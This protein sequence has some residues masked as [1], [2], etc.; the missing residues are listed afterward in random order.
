VTEPLGAFPPRRSAHLDEVAVAG[1]HGIAVD[2]L[3]RD[4]L[5]APALNRVVN[6]EHDGSPWREGCDQQAEQSTRGHPR[7]PCR[8]VEH[9]V[10]VHEPPLARQA[11]DAQ[12]A[13]H[14]ALVW[15]QDGTGQQHLG[16]TPTALKEQGREA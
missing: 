11:G 15:R 1:S 14:R 13:R 9:A 6:P 8:T 4:A 3:C 16:V 7:A 10:V 12:D 2:A 5:A